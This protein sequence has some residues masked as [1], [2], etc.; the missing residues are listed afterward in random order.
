MK[1]LSIK[2]VSQRT[3][4]PIGTLRFYIRTGQSPFDFRQLPSGKAVMAEEELRN[5]IDALPL[6]MPTK[7][8]VKNEKK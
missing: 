3:G 4:I 7:E 2:D 1:L 5:A 6:Y 8:T